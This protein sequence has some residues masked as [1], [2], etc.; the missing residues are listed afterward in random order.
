MTQARPT[1]RDETWTRR[2]ALLLVTVLVCLAL[3]G[4]PVDA[5]AQTSTQSVEELT[6][7]SATA[8]A[9]RPGGASMLWMYVTSLVAALGMMAAYAWRRSR[10]I[11]EITDISLAPSPAIVSKAT[12]LPELAALSSEERATLSGPLALQVVTDRPLFAP[13]SEGDQRVCPTCSRT[14]PTW[15]AICPHDATPLEPTRPPRPASS[16]RVKG[17][18]K[19]ARKRCPRCERRYESDASHCPIDGHELVEDSLEEALVAPPMHVCRF[20]GKES[21]EGCGKESCDVVTLEPA[22]LEDK[23]PALPLTRCPAC[24]RLGKPGQVR[25]EHDG[26]ELVPVTSLQ[27]HALPTVGFGPLRKMCPKCGERFSG[28]LKHCSYDGARLKTMD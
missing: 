24:N 9:T 19:L 6:R 23:R 16:K 4:A 1:A 8:S 7:D 28:H 25:C 15:M 3:W 5:V 20:C 17:K 21:L 14:F 22:K 26:V 11:P 13:R 2:F 18:N 10:R 27:L 12:Q